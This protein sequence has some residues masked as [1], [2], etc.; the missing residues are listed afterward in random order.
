M[1]ERTSKQAVQGKE[2]YA[3]FDDEGFHIFEKN[4]TIQMDEVRGASSVQQEADTKLFLCAKGCILLGASSICIHIIDTD[5][6]VPSFY[7]SARV[8]IDISMFK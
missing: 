3:T 1:T 5:V 2:I 8:N 4:D 6:L 7:Y